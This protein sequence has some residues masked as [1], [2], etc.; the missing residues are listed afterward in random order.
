MTIQEKSLVEG[1]FGS[2]INTNGGVQEK[3][4]PCIVQVIYASFI[5]PGHQS[6]DNASISS[7]CLSENDNY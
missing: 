4:G 5:P 1:V 2:W 7:V 3:W 6:T